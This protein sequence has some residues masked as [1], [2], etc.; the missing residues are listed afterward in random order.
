MTQA[1]WYRRKAEECAR[2]A[3]EATKA[4][5]RAEHEHEEKLWLQIAEQIE[6]NERNRFGSAPV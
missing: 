4:H 6:E 5:R 3:V 1:S 2:M